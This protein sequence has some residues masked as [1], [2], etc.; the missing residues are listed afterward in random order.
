MPKLVAKLTDPERPIIAHALST[1]A[2]QYDNDAL[3]AS[4]LAL[5]G[6]LA[7]KAAAE[8][9]GEQLRQEAADARQLR[10]KI[11]FLWSH[12]KL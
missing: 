3:F 12:L 7:T 2:A 1:A 10:D 5:R 9:L 4:N 6:G 11:T 8:A